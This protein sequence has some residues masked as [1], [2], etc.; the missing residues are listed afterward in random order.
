M[1]ELFQIL[2]GLISY[3]YPY[4]VILACVLLMIHT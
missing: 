1:L 4:A 2:K 3:V